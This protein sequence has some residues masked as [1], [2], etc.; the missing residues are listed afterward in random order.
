MLHFAGV[1]TAFRLCVNGVF[2]GYSEDSMGPAE[3]DVTTLVRAGENV[4]AAECYKYSSA[5]YLEDQDFWRLS[6]IFRSVFAYSTAEVFIADAAVTADPE[7]GTVRAEVEVERWDG[8]LSLELVVRDP[9]GAIAAQA[10]GGRSLAAP[11]P[12]PKRWS[13]ET[14]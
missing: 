8:S 12:A 4:V 10:S 13:A 9:S 7:S 11:G 6:G 1:Q 2:A 5:S 3:F 14:P